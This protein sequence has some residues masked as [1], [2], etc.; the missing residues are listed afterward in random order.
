LDSP[1]LRLLETYVKK[2]IDILSMEKYRKSTKLIIAW[3]L[4]GTMIPKGFHGRLKSKSSFITVLIKKLV[5]TLL[6]VIISNDKVGIE[7][8]VDMKMT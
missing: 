3:F 1:N 5:C 4:V 7:H 8:H 2:Y 6:L